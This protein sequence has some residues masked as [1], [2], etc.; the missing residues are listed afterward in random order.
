MRELELF[1]YYN[2]TVVYVDSPK[3][4]KRY[5]R[6]ISYNGDP[7]EWRVGANTGA[8][9]RVTEVEYGTD[10]IW[11]VRLS[12]EVRIPKHYTALVGLLAHEATH[13]VDFLHESVGETHPGMEAKAYMTQRIITFLA[14]CLHMNK[15]KSQKAVVAWFENRTRNV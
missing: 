13:V 5:L 10:R 11:I 12:K 2:K 7:I 8:A 14:D 15:P 4:L 3:D 9:A 1:P 6:G